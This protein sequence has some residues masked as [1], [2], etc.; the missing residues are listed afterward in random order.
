ME[1]DKLNN[2]QLEQ[3]LR[4]WWWNRVWESRAQMEGVRLICRCE[5]TQS[6]TFC[7]R[8][9][10]GERG[11]RERSHDLVPSLFSSGSG[12]PFCVGGSCNFLYIVLPF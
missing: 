3:D 9:K 10:A 8:K 11:R 2:P 12:N 7:G 6:D 4:S 5:W 1:L